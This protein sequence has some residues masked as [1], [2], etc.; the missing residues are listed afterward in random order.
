MLD[1][2]RPDLDYFL[3]LA[4]TAR[5]PSARGCAAC[6]TSISCSSSSTLRG[7]ASSRPTR[8]APAGASGCSQRRSGRR[9]ATSSCTRSGSRAQPPVE[10]VADRY[11]LTAHWGAPEPGWEVEPNDWREAANTV[12]VGASVR[13]YLGSADDKDWF[14]L[15]P[16]ADGRLLRPRPR[17]RGRRRDGH[18][19]RARRQ[20][21]DGSRGAGAR[22]GVLLPA[23]AGQPVIV[24]VTRKPMAPGTSKT[25]GVPGLE[26]PYELRSELDTGKAEP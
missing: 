22:G 10:N 13:G 12:A 7:G 9:A 6:P 14:S 3:I 21:T 8:A 15:T 16:N 23:H 26:E 2:G 19:R 4:A 1:G 25:E 24:G 20:A 11:T 18:L 17:A 5:A